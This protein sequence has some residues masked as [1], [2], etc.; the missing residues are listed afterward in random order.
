MTITMDKLTWGDSHGGT[1]LR[2][3]LICNLGL[4]EGELASPRMNSFIGCPMQSGHYVCK[5]Q[6]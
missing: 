1:D 2:Q 6:K 3:K 5:Q 4:L